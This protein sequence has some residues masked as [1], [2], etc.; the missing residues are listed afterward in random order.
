VEEFDPETKDE[1]EIEAY[2]E[3]SAE[4]R[5]VTDIDASI[6]NDITVKAYL[7]AIEYQNGTLADFF[8]RDY[9]EIASDMTVL[10]PLVASL[11]AG[12][13]AGLDFITL[14]DL[15]SFSKTGS[16]GYKD[17]QTDDL[18]ETSIY[19]NVDR[20]IYKPGG[21]ALTNEALRAHNAEEVFER[22]YEIS[23][24]SCF[25]L[26]FTAT[27]SAAFTLSAAARLSNYVDYYKNYN[28]IC[29]VIKNNSKTISVL[30]QKTDAL[31]VSSKQTLLK[32]NTNLKMLINPYN[33]H[34]LY[35]QYQTKSVL[36][37]NLMVGF[38]VATMILSLISFLLV[39]QD[40]DNYYKVDYTPIPRYIVDEKDITAY[41]GKGEKI[42]IKNQAAYYKVVPCNREE[43][44]K[45]YKVLGTAGDLNGTVGQQWLALYAAKNENE[46]PIISSSL[47]AVVGS[48]N[49]PA[50]YTTG[51]HMFGSES[52]YN[53]N[54]TQLIWNNEAKSVYVYFNVDTS[55]SGSLT[56]G[57]SF[58][59]GY[60]IL[61]A[62]G[63]LAV[64]AIGAACVVL[65]AKKKKVQA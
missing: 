3:A 23:T 64:G 22:D 33:E 59:A 21:V 62:V 31:S 53:L 40:I 35:V 42:V 34:G 45:W 37:K 14:S 63:G 43:D 5:V 61:A 9:K 55:A 13:R 1:S 26:A 65:A 11:S 41:N 29:E 46:S 48:D 30:R 57:S 54:N 10:Y 8:M 12:Q 24:L 58:T 36:C 50:D 39:L 28:K 60:I 7:S 32:E 52:A 51:I 38:G 49:I 17:A 25:F 2:A 27:T 16:D 56:T 19:E 20:D 4:I 15:I 18:T 47:K 44:D 6:L